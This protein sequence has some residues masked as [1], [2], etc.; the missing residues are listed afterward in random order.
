[1]M[2]HP[3]V[4]LGCNIY[5]PFPCVVL[6]W[7]AGSL[8]D[9]SRLCHSWRRLCGISLRRQSAYYERVGATDERKV[10]ADLRHLLTSVSFL[11]S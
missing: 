1:M 10:P 3:P 2:T 6:S 9:R 7:E 8:K 11:I 4:S 5:F